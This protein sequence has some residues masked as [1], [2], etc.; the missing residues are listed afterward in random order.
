MARCEEA[1]MLKDRIMM[2]ERRKNRRT[3]ERKG[4]NTT[5]KNRETD[6]IFFK[7]KLLKHNIITHKI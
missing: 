7:F 2:T 1:G 5:K 3:E 4:K 6:T